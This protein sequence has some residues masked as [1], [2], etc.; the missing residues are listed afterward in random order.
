[1]KT[2]LILLMLLL[3]VFAFSQKTIA[4][5]NG[6]N[7]GDQ[8]GRHVAMSGDGKRL[9]IGAPFSDEHGSKSGR[10]R[11]YQQT[12]N[13]WV[14]LG[15][16][17]LGETKGDNMG[18]IVALSK[19]G[20]TLAVGV[21]LSTPT[22]YFD[23]YVYGEGNWKLI[24]TIHPNDDPAAK[25]DFVHSVSLSADGSFIAVGFDKGTNNARVQV[26]RKN[27]STWEKFG[28]QLEGGEYMDN[29]GESIDLSDDGS[30][31]AIGASGKDADS[32]VRN[33]G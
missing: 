2:T 12:D 11:V 10:V 21:P 33:V 7:P 19:D 16:D 28:Q 4:H 22:G 5:F 3:P 27:D 29:F 17:I 18:E 25:W 26:Y 32:K 6:E 30:T 23:I 8:L 24:T 31:L 9:A 15:A 13:D 1:M 14:Q 20:N